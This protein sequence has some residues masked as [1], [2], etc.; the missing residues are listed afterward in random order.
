LNGNQGVVTAGATAVIALA[1]IVTAWITAALAKENRLL[2]KA[3]TEPEVVAY[4]MADPRF[5]NV[6]NLVLANIGQGPALDVE[7]S[8]DGDQADFEAHEVRLRNDEHRKP[9]AVLPHAERLTAF[10]GTGPELLK[11]PQ[12]KPFAMSLTYA[13]VRRKRRARRFNLDVA[14]FK[15]ISTVGRPSDYEAA[16]ALKQIA[17]R[18]KDWSSGFARL[19]VEAIT[20]AE[21]ERRDREFVEK[22]RRDKT[23]A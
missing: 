12:L 14:Q 5:P 11:E 4:L 1:S 22:A 21:R 23:K 3:G 9:I 18:I 8:L 19:K 6:V 16:E 7:F 17:D 2:R 20:T 10:F 15:G 13:D